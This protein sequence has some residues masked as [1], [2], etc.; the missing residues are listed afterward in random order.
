MKRS[1]YIAIPAYSGA[2]NVPTVACLLAATGELQ[3]V[4]VDVQVRFSCGDSILSRARNAFVADF[5]RQE[6]FT[7]L[8]FI[9]SDV[10][11]NRGALTQLLSHPVDL[12]GGAYPKKAEPLEWPVLFKRDPVQWPDSDTGLVEV[13]GIPAGFMRLTRAGLLVMTE[14]FT[15]R[16]YRDRKQDMQCWA[17]FDQELI[18]DQWW[19]EDFLFCRRW[20][21]AGMPVWL[22][23]NIAFGHMGAKA[24]EG[25]IAQSLAKQ[26]RPAA[27]A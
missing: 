19:G 14:H 9:D 24:Y 13:D 12:V 17:L 5:L 26:P 10:S 6:Q 4:G 16:R 20:Q 27:A 18:G 3:S 23:P 8:V 11:W 2:V 1:I 7:D 22:D 25:C 15:D 21:E